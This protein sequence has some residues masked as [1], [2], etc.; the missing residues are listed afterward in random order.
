MLQLKWFGQLFCHPQ[1]KNQ[2]RPQCEQANLIRP[3]LHISRGCWPRRGS[4]SLM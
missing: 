1:Q 2:L 4:T 3:A